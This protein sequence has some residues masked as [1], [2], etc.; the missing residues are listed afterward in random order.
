M[1]GVRA[2]TVA[3]PV[4]TKTAFEDAKP[5]ASGCSQPSAMGTPNAAKSS[6]RV[7]A[8]Y[9]DRLDMWLYRVWQFV[10]PNEV[11]LGYGA[12]GQSTLSWRQGEGKK[13]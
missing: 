13:S 9:L 3:E 10:C 11:A 12:L 6:S 4:A 1:T 8:P 5:P 2:M 7:R